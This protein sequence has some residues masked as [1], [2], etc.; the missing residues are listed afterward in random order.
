MA[1]AELELVETSRGMRLACDPSDDVITR[2]L[3]ETGTWEEGVA[4]AIEQYLE[5][6]WLFLDLGAHIGYFS[7]LAAQR[8]NRVIA[9][10]ANRDYA[11]LLSENAA[12]N[13]QDINIQAIA[14]GTTSGFGYLRPDAR[15]KDNPGAAYLA[16]HPAGQPTPIATLEGILGSERPEFIK[17]DLEGLEYDIIAANPEIVAGAQVM[18]VEV[19]AEMTARYGHSMRDV[20]NLLQESGF[21]VRLMDGTPVTPDLALPRDHYANLLARRVTAVEQSPE[22]A[23]A[24]PATGTQ[25]VIL[26]AWRNL[27]A[28]T[29]ECMMHLQARGWKWMIKR[30][31]ALITRGRSIAVSSWYRQTDDDV[32]LMI[33]DDVVFLPEHAEKV[34]A[35]AREK[36]SVACAAYPVKDGTHLACRAIPGKDILFGPK[37]EPVEIYYPATGFMAVH[38]DVI[39]AM[40]EAP[41]EY[42]GKRFPQCGVGGLGEMWPFFD[43]FCIQHPNG[44]WEYLSEDYA[45]GEVARQLG[46]TTWLDPSIELYH[47]GLFPY[48]VSAMTTARN[49]EVPE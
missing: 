14:V 9:V 21:E 5:P 25:T 11:R 40:I 49:V 43:T 10:E 46:F 33:D 24:E 28:E 17:L 13:G 41:G 22:S 36:R 6:G 48:R 2:A 37:S 29:S 7:L 15:F 4:L 45:F 18:V 30:G 42:G 20:I 19:G 12:R 39:T 16:M 1:V 34:I 27:L 3:R 8:G 31:D 38:R 23:R 26:C 35:L 32:F 44:D 47:M